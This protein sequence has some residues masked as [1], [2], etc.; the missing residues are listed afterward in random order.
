[1]IDPVEKKSISVNAA[2]KAIL[3]YFLATS[4]EEKFSEPWPLQFRCDD[5]QPGL[6]RRASAVA[7]TFEDELIKRMARVARLARPQPASSLGPAR[8]LFAFWR[9]FENF[10]VAREAVFGGQRRMA[11]DPGAPSRSYLKLE[12][13]FG[14]LG[15]E[16]QTGETVVDLGA[17]P[18]GW[19]F[20][21]AK[22]GASVLALDNGPLKGA[23][24]GHPLIE[25][26]RADAF[27]FTPAPG[28]VY[29]W[30]F[31]DVVDDPDKVLGLLERWVA[32][33]ACRRFVVNLKFGRTDPLPL[34][35]RAVGPS[36]TLARACVRLRARHLFHD[37]E[38]F[39][40]VG[41]LRS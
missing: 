6:A 13:A 8:G 14:L 10:Y 38:E 32:Q 19:S 16:P 41:E 9:D 39:T 7:R 37:R 34:L 3:E 26:E 36:S 1:M 4:R 12:E 29:D 18:G 30:L 15:R 27:R 20:C 23:A 28:K 17:A 33:H 24:L 25:H 22:R 21:A 31:C 5:S 40:L 2:A 35:H 11:D